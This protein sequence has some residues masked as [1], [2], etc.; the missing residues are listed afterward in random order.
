LSYQHSN[1][2][3]DR[4]SICCQLERFSQFPMPEARL[5]KIA[6]AP[7]MK[8]RLLSEIKLESFVS[9]DQIHKQ[10]FDK[11]VEPPG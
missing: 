10:D 8:N 2:D 9:H 6:M 1:Q 3:R 4:A 11:Q 5:I 7:P